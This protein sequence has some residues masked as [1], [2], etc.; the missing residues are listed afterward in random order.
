M[1]NSISTISHLVPP[2]QSFVNFVKQELRDAGLV[3]NVKRFQNS[4]RIVMPNWT[5]EKDAQLHDAVRNMCMGLVNVSG[6]A[7][8]AQNWKIARSLFNGRASWFIYV[9]ID[10]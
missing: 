6:E 5:A 8:T 1:T 2:N 9:R 3:V 10:D 7:F 4:I